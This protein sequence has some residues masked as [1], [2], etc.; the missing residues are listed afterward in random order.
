MFPLEEGVLGNRGSP[1]VPPVRAS[2][3][4]VVGLFENAS[5]AREWAEGLQL[6]NSDAC[7]NGL[8]RTAQDD[9]FVG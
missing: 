3:G 9:L 1:I 7:M 8:F 2:G 6:P 4:W 5:A